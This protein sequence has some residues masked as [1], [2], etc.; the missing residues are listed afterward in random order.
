MAMHAGVLD[1]Y[2][3]RGISSD[4]ANGVHDSWL[5]AAH[6]LCNEQ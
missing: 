6:D 3:V 5:T 2:T 4:R 1:E